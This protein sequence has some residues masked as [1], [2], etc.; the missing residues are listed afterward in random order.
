MTE[1][2]STPTGI[3]IS[4]RTRTLDPA[5]ALDGFAERLD[6]ARGAL[7]SSG[8][9]YPGRYS[10]WEFGFIDPPLEIVGSGRTLTARALNARGDEAARRSSSPRSPTRRRS[11]SSR[12]SPAPLSIE[13]A[14]ERPLR[15]RGGRAQPAAFARSRRCA[16]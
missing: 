13:I 2:F 4:R 1:F 5:N 10:R 6:G 9:D 11:G 15:F 14:A 3:T 12:T 7:F 16:G 8:I